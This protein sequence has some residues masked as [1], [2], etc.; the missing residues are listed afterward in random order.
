MA[1]LRALPRGRYG[2]HGERQHGKWEGGRRL[3]DEHRRSDDS[4]G[5][6]RS[7][8][9]ERDRARQRGRDRASNRGGNRGGG[10]GQ[11]RGNDGRQGSAGGAGRGEESR[12]QQSKRHKGPNARAAAAA[13][14]TTAAGMAYGRGS[15]AALWAPQYVTPGAAAGLG[16]TNKLMDAYAD[17]LDE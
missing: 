8:S 15:G 9:A 10:R 3:S 11:K 7:G 17:G 16:D 2:R 4:R 5:H 6:R 14:Y 1:L 13:M 12:Q